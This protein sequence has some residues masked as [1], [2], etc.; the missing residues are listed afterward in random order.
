M[1]EDAFPLEPK[2]NGS[3][4]GTL[5]GGAAR[6]DRA[7]P[8]R[9]RFGFSST[10]RF[11]RG[12]SHSPQNTQPLP[13]ALPRP[14]APARPEARGPPPPMEDRKK[15]PGLGALGAVSAVRGGGGGSRLPSQEGTGD[16][17]GSEGVGR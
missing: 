16:A 14:A 17:E 4:R 2:V 12:L 13:T 5:Q 11:V 6:G 1:Q 15:A 9:I 7:P 10:R 8:P 3:E